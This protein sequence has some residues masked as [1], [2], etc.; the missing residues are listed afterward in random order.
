MTKTELRQIPE[1]IDTFQ[2]LVKCSICKTYSYKKN[3]RFHKKE[4]RYGD[5]GR[6]V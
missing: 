2:D 4:H 1:I 5:N 6:W 3:W